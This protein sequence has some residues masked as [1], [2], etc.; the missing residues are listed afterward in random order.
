MGCFPSGGPEPGGGSRWGLLGQIPA[1]ALLF[2]EA[3]SAV[4]DPQSGSSWA[5][6][7]FFIPNLFPL[8]HF[9]SF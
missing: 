2:L 5:W 9:L 8:W 3:V 1:L 6:A 4:P 7:I